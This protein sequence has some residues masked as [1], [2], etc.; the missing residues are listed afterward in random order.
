VPDAYDILLQDIRTDRFYKTL[1]INKQYYE[2]L[3]SRRTSPM[4]PEEQLFA[5]FFQKHINILHPYVQ[6][7]DILEIRAYREKMAL[8]AK[9]GKAA[10]YAADKAEKEVKKAKNNSAKNANL[11]GFDRSLEQ[12]GVTSNAINVIK[13]RQKR[14]SKQEK[15]H[16]MLMDIPG[17]S[18]AEASQ[19]LSNTE[20]LKRFK[21][22]NQG[23]D[24]EKLKAEKV[25]QEENN[26]PMFNPFEK[27]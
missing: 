16:K 8:I 20:L 19:M 26:K 15:L 5:D 2:H 11:P 3:Y 27:K 1:D 14:L 13:D 21:N 22:K 4:T 18:A 23:E 6:D 17:M 12:D 24:L 10:V 9:E 25:I 7:M